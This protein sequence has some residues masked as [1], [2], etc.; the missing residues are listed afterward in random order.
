MKNIRLKIYTCYLQ[1][2]VGLPVF[3]GFSPAKIS[4]FGIIMDKITLFFPAPFLGGAK[5]IFYSR[6]F[7]SKTEI[8][9]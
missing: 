3:I 7:L 2:S 9:S 8:K 5:R 6:L 1:N 4:R